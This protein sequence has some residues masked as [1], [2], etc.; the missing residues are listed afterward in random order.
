MEV[1]KDQ[2]DA[3]NDFRSYQTIFEYDTAGNVTRSITEGLP[4]GYRAYDTF[5]NVLYEEDAAGVAT[6]FNYDELGRLVK[7]AIVDPKVYQ[8]RYDPPI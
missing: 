2:T 5:G 1:P 3:P 7:S 8:V 6:A 4:S